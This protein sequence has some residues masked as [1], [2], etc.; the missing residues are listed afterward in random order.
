[1]LGFRVVGRKIEN[2]A[3]G[4]GRW[5]HTYILQHPAVPA[6][7]GRARQQHTQPAP[8]PSNKLPVAGG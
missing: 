4:L 8:R 5:P 1:M 7:L 3:D 2:V 6:L